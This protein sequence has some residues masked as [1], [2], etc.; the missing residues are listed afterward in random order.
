MTA[1]QTRDAIEAYLRERGGWVPIAILADWMA[2]KLLLSPGQGMSDLRV[3]LRD[4]RIQRRATTDAHPVKKR[5][6]Y[7]ALGVTP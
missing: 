4:G 6:E 5:Y 2:R 7:A 1:P 3:L